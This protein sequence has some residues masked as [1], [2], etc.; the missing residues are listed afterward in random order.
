[1]TAF[2]TLYAHLKAMNYKDAPLFVDGKL[3]FLNVGENYHLLYSDNALFVI[4]FVDSVVQHYWTNKDELRVE[5]KRSNDYF[6]MLDKIPYTFSHLIPAYLYYCE[7]SGPHKPKTSILDVWPDAKKYN[8]IPPIYSTTECPNTTKYDIEKLFLNTI[9]WIGKYSYISKLGRQ[10]HGTRHWYFDLEEFCLHHPLANIDD[11]RQSFYYCDC[12][13][14]GQSFKRFSNVY[15]DEIKQFK[16]IDKNFTDEWKKELSSKNIKLND[17][18]LSISNLLS[19]SKDLNMLRWH[20]VLVNKL[21]IKIDLKNSFYSIFKNNERK[22]NFDFSLDNGCWYF[23]GER[24]IDILREDY[25]PSLN[26]QGYFSDEN[27]FTQNSLQLLISYNREQIIHISE[28]L[29][30]CHKNE[31]N[32]FFTDL[33]KSVE[34]DMAKL[35]KMFKVLNEYRDAKFNQLL[36]VREVI[37][38]M[39]QDYFGDAPIV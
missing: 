12:E 31:M 10:E 29:N 7:T 23:D 15:K 33:E 25:L 21:L 35:D 26:T 6:N 8:F 3:L 9:G 32:S 28:L 22:I 36:N 20:P 19:N 37:D 2:E 5:Q 39:H 16:H 1:M 27:R 30:I 4:N 17:M 11:D 14:D 24:V 38:K 18:G 34:N 13:Y